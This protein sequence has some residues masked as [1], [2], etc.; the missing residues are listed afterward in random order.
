MRCETPKQ[1]GEG[2][3]EVSCTEPL[4]ADTRLRLTATSAKDAYFLGFTGAC[5]GSDPCELT[6]NE[7]RQEVT[8]TFLLRDLCTDKPGKTRFCW[9]NPRPQG[10]PLYSVA[11]RSPNDVWIVGANS[12]ILHWNGSFWA[13]VPVP[14]GLSVRPL[15][16]VWAHGDEVYVCG[17]QGALLSWDGA[18]FQIVK[19]GVE[20]GIEA[21][22]GIPPPNGAAGPADLWLVGSD[23]LIL[24]RE[25]GAFRQIPSGLGRGIS[26][27][28]IWARRSD[29]VWFVGEQGTVLRYDGSALRSVP[30]GTQL[31]LASVV[32]RPRKSGADEVFIGGHD[33]SNLPEVSQGVVL[34]WEGSSFTTYTRPADV[35]ALWVGDTGPLWVIYSGFISGTLVNLAFVE[36]FD[37]SSFA[38]VPLPPDGIP[39]IF[40]GIN[41]SG[42]DD[43]WIVG[44][45]GQI[46]HWNGSFLHAGTSGVR[47]QLY[48]IWVN[49]PDAVWAVGAAGTILH[50][51]GS[52]WVPV[53]STTTASLAA[54]WGTP[55]KEGRLEQVWVAGNLGV[56]ARWDGGSFKRLLLP[57]GAPTLRSISGTPDG[58]VWLVGGD[59]FGDP[60]NERGRAYRGRQ[61]SEM[62]TEVVLPASTRG[63][64]QVWAR[65]TNDVWLV[66]SGG[67]ALRY[68]GNSFTRLSGAD[69]LDLKLVFGTGRDDV[70]IAGDDGSYLPQGQRRLLRWQGQGLAQVAAPSGFIFGRLWGQRPDDLWAVGLDINVQANILHFDGTAFNPVPGTFVNVAAV[71][72][73]GDQTYVA[74][75]SGSILRL[76]RP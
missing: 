47:I 11:A 26:L 22:F 19:T 32:G 70:W 64:R 72:G 9:E 14:D 12:T 50:R 30:S 76:D 51:S 74:G 41:G 48:D 5:S 60:Q 27:S 16:G 56:V 23:G 55:A 13:P 57:A 44:N 6:I 20:A 73:A 46:L 71:G 59:A 45:D 37:G 2:W 1:S 28:A 34:R 10:S 8:A 67:T 43:L 33:F 69:G 25:N 15:G 62:L 40:P 61:D 35:Q 7:G 52:A 3:D 17:Q 24:H 75:S 4:P 66:G 53:A 38:R 58:E 29:D 42:P 18:A 31:A 63:L 21:V 49:G 39:F 68:N 36:R 65:A 54:L